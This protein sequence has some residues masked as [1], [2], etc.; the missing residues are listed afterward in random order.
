[1]IKKLLLLGILFFSFLQSHFFA[2]TGI[3]RKAENGDW[4]FARTLEFGSDLLTFDLL[5]VPRGISYKGSTPSG[6]SGLSWSTKYGHVGFAPFDLPLLADGIN[7]KGLVCAAFYFPGW[8]EFQKVKPEEASQSISNLDFVSWVLGNFATVPEALEAIKQVKVTGVV[9]KEWGFSPPL[10]F[11]IVDSKGNR[12]IIEYVDGTM[13]SYDA[14][15]MT[16]TN[17]PTY[18][19]HETNAR[20][21][22]GLRALN[23]PSIKINGKDLS[24]F[25]QGSGAIGLPGDFTSPSRFIRAG[26][27][28]EVVFAGKTGSDEVINAFKILNQFDIPKGAV[29]ENVEGK[30]V[31]EVTQWTSASDLSKRQYFFHTFSDRTLRMVDLNKVDLNGKSIKKIHVEEPQKIEDLSFN[32]R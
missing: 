25:S 11:I 9:L 23:R 31:P 19:W 27:F 29:R 30:E 8:A 24:Q 13:K 1:M 26:F 4:V 18:S 22:I 3:I 15:L 6:D 32:F 28:R 20:N 5:F 12:V 2:C 16:I 14:P 21:Y 17:S 10:H 7:E